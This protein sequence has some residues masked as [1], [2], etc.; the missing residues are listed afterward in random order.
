MIGCNTLRMCLMCP[1]KPMLSDVSAL[2]AV[3][4]KLSCFSRKQV[5]DPSLVK[6]KGHLMASV[7]T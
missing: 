1:F 3:T 6:H 7:S 5:T 4:D 2:I